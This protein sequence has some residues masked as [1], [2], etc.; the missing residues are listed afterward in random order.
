MKFL[1]SHSE[2][3]GRD[4]FLKRKQQIKCHEMRNESNQSIL[5]KGNRNPVENTQNEE[6]H[7]FLGLEGILGHAWFFVCL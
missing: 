5:F 4:K 6:E 1:T 2:V 7:D 3:T